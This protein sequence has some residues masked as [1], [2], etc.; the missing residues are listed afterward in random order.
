MKAV[1]I[2]GMSDEKVRARLLPLTKLETMTN[3]F[4]VRR[5]PL[6]LE[7]VKTYSPPSFL[8]WSLF[9]EEFDRIL[10]IIF[11]C[12]KE[13]PDYLYGIYFVP[14][15]LYAAIIGRIFNIPVI[16]ELIGTDRNLVNRSKIYQKLLIGANRISV[17]GTNSLNQLSELLGIPKENFF[18]SIAVNAIDFDLFKPEGSGKK[19]DLVYCG[20]LDQNKQVDLIIE[21]FFHVYK[22]NP[23]LKLLIVGNGPERENLEAKASEYEINPNV[24]FVGRQ[25]YEDIPE[26]LNQSRVFI[27][28]SQSEGLPVAMIE[29]L[30]CGLPVIVPDVG[31]ISDIA[32][33]EYNGWLVEENGLIAYEEAL[34][35]ILN[36]ISLYNKLHTGALETREDFLNNFTILNAKESWKEILK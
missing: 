12:I 29:A 3:I 5:F 14:H 18:I 20:H 30:S 22:K 2:C 24:T 36:D 32:I 8:R 10:T 11:L 17:R 35:A 26:L 9:L 34:S 23:E 31:D 7:K 33:H 28:A 25:D 19:Y 6:S 4:L 1:V 15:G 21:A 27:M 13:K 16:Q